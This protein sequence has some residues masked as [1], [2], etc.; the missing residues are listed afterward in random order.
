GA[1]VLGDLRVWGWAGVAGALAVAREPRPVTRRALLFGHEPG[2]EGGEPPASTT[3]RPRLR[4][5]EPDREQIELAFRPL[6]LNFPAPSIH[7]RARE[8]AWA[9]RWGTNKSSDT[10]HARL[11][12]WPP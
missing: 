3:A 2:F 11:L 12:W 10:A 1:C 9:R 8:G 6:I 5:A 4:L 7:P